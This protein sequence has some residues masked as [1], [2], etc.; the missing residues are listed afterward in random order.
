[1]PTRI[2]PINLTIRYLNPITGLVD[3]S[4]ISPF[5]RSC[6][7]DRGKPKITLVIDTDGK[8]SLVHRWRNKCGHIDDDNSIYMEIEAQCLAVGCVVIAA[9]DTH[10][11]YCGEGCAVTAGQWAVPVRAQAAALAAAAARRSGR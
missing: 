2:K 10:Y 8:T 11:P 5:C 9:P 1:M 3:T 7:D 4:I 6:G